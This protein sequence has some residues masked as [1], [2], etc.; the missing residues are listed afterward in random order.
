MKKPL[1]QWK[2]P[3]LE[4]GGRRI[5]RLINTIYP[6]LNAKTARLKSSRKTVEAYLFLL[7]KAK[8]IFKPLRFLSFLFTFSMNSCRS[9]FFASVI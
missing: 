9:S 5:W 3:G 7:V 1:R 8:R 6:I 2:K 4:K